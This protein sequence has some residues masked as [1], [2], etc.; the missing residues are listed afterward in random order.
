[1]IMSHDLI[2]IS[3]GREGIT[4]FMMLI[5]PKAEGL[6]VLAVSNLNKEIISRS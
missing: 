2:K 4:K 1:M 3:V 5:L 6:E